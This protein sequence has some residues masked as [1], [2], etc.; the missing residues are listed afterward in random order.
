MLICGDAELAALDVDLAQL[1][2]QA[3]TAAPDKQAFAN[4]TRQNWNWRERNCRDKACL[5]GRYADQKQ[6]FAAAIA[7][8]NQSAASLASSVTPNLQ[9]ITACVTS[10]QTSF[11]CSIPTFLDEKAICGDPGLAAMDLEMADYYAAAVKQ[12]SAEKLESDQHD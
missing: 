6:L 3:K 5:V 11:D 1:Y 4:T 12:G 8:P 10:Y 7:N 9:G 2:M